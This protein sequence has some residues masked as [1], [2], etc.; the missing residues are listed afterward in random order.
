VDCAFKLIRRDLLEPI[1]LSA[2]GAM[3]STELVAKL[4]RAGAR[5]EER[6][7]THRPRLAGESSGGD[8]RVVARAFAEL[9]RMRRTLAGGG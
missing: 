8:P 4:M 7:V 2:G 5:V 1:E 9:V 3:I 6:E